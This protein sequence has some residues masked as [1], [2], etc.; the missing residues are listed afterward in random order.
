MA[1]GVKGNLFEFY[2]VYREEGHFSRSG[3]KEGTTVIWTVCQKSHF[4][5][6]FFLS[7]PDAVPEYSVCKIHTQSPVGQG[8]SLCFSYH[9]CKLSCSTPEILKGLAGKFS[10]PACN[11][12][13]MC[14]VLQ[15]SKGSTGLDMQDGPSR[16]WQLM[17]PAG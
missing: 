16:G 8:I 14:T 1:C 6:F 11:C 2:L 3:K 5:F 7:L 4:D 9:C 13:Q 10:V 12:S 17:L 15:M